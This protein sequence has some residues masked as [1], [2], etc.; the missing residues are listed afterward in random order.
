MAVF[1]VQVGDIEPGGDVRVFAGVR[2][3]SLDW[4]ADS[5]AREG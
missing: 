2:A 3:G 4:H 5:D 1:I